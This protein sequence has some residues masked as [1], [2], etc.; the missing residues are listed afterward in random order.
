MGVRR[1]SNQCQ[2][3]VELLLF[4]V[5]CLVATH[6]CVTAVLVVVVIVTLIITIIIQLPVRIDKQTLTVHIGSPDVDS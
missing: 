3:E 2:T 4:H 1:Q 5:V 6:A